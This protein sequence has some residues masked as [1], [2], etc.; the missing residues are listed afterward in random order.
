MDVQWEILKYSPATGGFS[1][2]NV[3]SLS[4]V[5]DSLWPHGLEPTS[6]LCPRDS[7]GKSTRAGSLSLL[8]GIFLTQGLNLHLLC[9]LH[10]QADSL[11]LVPPEKPSHG[12]GGGNFNI[13]FQSDH[14][15]K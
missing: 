1:P 6:L 12:V 7:P 8:Q 4:V 5:S 9:L 15:R 10:W 14:F 2:N 11:P 3:L 13:N